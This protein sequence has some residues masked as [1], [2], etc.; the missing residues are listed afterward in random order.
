MPTESTLRI[1][2]ELTTNIFEMPAFVPDILQR[3]YYLILKKS[4]TKFLLSWT[5][6][7][8]G[9]LRYR[10]LSLSQPLSNIFAS[11]PALRVEHLLK[12][13]PSGKPLSPCFLPFLSKGLNWIGD[14]GRHFFFIYAMLV[15]FIYAMLVAG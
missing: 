14:W 11:K 1:K 12:W 8:W 3:I 15:H 2:K 13:W 4:P 6:C 5:L 10:W 7:F 9:P